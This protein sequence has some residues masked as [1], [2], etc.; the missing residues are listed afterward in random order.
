MLVDMLAFELGDD[1]PGRYL[2]ALA[3]TSVDDNFSNENNDDNHHHM[4]VDLVSQLMLCRCGTSLQATTSCMALC[5][6]T[7]ATQE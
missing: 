2:A 5:L 4:F 1:T 7:G 3:G 6:P